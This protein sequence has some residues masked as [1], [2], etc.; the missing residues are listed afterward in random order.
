[1]GMI[2]NSMRYIPHCH[3]LHAY[4]HLPAVPS[5]LALFSRLLVKG[6][7][8]VTSRAR[9][10]AKNKQSSASQPIFTRLQYLDCRLEG[11]SSECVCLQKML[12]LSL[13]QCLLLLTKD[14]MVNRNRGPRGRFSRKVNNEVSLSP[15]THENNQLSKP[16]DISKRRRLNDGSAQYLSPTPVTPT[17]AKEIRSPTKPPHSAQA[18]ELKQL[19]QDQKNYPLRTA[20][21]ADQVAEPV[22]KPSAPKD[23]R[24]LRS[25]DNIRPRSELTN[26]FA[27]FN[28]VVYGD[29]DSHGKTCFMRSCSTLFLTSRRYADAGYFA[30]HCQFYPP[31]L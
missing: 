23:K 22:N 8:V 30:T 25:Q 10:A 19:V 14:R 1:M 11:D 15:Q 24:T 17:P 27:D 7:L 13:P 3:V 12:Q 20:Y 16:E 28:E 6:Q 2:L 26:F 18:H 5:R 29:T 21:D 31:S 9:R 4:S